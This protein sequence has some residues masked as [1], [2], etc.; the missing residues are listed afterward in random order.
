MDIL[1][2]FQFLME[3]KGLN[4]KELAEK[5]GKREP[6]ISKWLNG[7]Q[8]FTLK[9]LCKL[10]IALGDEIISIPKH[11]VTTRNV[12]VPPKPISTNKKLHRKHPSPQK[13]GKQELN[14][15]YAMAA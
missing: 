1:D 14:S 11:F 10:E 7:V 9:T 4:Q 12:P 6:E 13:A 2:R 15:D 8:N 5:M 3:S